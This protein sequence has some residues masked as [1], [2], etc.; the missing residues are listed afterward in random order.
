MT[1]DS[2]F[3]YPDFDLGA[4]RFAVARYVKL[5]IRARRKHQPG[6]LSRDELAQWHLADIDSDRLASWRLLEQAAATLGL[7]NS[8]FLP[9]C[10]SGG[11]RETDESTPE[12]RLIHE[13]VNLAET[14]GGGPYHNLALLNAAIALRRGRAVNWEKLVEWSRLPAIRA[15]LDRLPFPQRARCP[16]ATGSV[17]VA[18]PKHIFSRN[19]KA[20]TISYMDRT[21]PKT[22]SVGLFYIGILLNSPQVSFPVSRLRAIYT[23]WQADP[24]SPL[25]TQAEWATIS[26][27]DFEDEDADP[28]DHLHPL[29]H[30][31]GEVLDPIG[32]RSYERHV[33]E[34]HYAIDD[35]RSKGKQAQAD[36]LEEELRAVEKELESGRSLGGR[37]RKMSATSKKDRDAVCTAIR[38]ALAGLQE[39]HRALCEHLR[40]S[41]ILRH[42]CC[43]APESPT[44]WNQ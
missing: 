21:I 7:L 41:L 10:G 9:R 24:S 42:V 38:R 13:V 11:V 14:E 19:G 29:G 3:F 23:S 26:G 39:D 30:D 8:E 1:S 22:H 5:L 33:E 44:T 27:S 2:H 16:Q 17:E 20:W 40:R 12:G 18:A 32:R 6:F 15:D 43:Y 4:F 25:R 36:E 35:L 34:L 28:S 37:P 31:L